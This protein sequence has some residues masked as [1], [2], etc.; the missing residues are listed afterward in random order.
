MTTTA[1]EALPLLRRVAKTLLIYCYVR[2]VVYFV[3]SRVQVVI[4]ERG[5]RRPR[6][7]APCP[8]DRRIRSSPI[9]G[10]RQDAAPLNLKISADIQCVLLVILRQSVTEL[11]GTVA[12]GPVLHTYTQYSAAVCSR[13]EAAIATSYL[14][15]LGG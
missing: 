11:C 7:Y 3:G 6:H 8:R 13:H 9:D 12:A 10:V 4:T 14:A 5:Y 15:G 1:L 2:Y